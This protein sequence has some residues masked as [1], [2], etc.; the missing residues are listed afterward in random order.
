MDSWY[1][2]QDIMLAIEKYRKVYYYPLK[3]NWQVDNLAWTETEKLHGKLI[4]IKGFL[5]IIR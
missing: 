3:G 1:A 2:T 4:K 5:A